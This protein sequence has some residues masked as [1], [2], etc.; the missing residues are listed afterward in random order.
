LTEHTTHYENTHIFYANHAD[1]N[2]T[3]SDNHLL[4]MKII[5]KT[6][7]IRADKRGLYLFLIKYTSGNIECATGHLKSQIRQYTDKDIE[8]ITIDFEL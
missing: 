5:D 6:S 4:I 3:C 2:C 7:H 8:S 1:Y